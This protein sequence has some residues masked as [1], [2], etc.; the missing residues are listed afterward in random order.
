MAFFLLI[1]PQ[2]PRV[3]GNCRPTHST[4]PHLARTLTECEAFFQDASCEQTVHSPQFHHCLKGSE[5]SMCA[6]LAG[7]FLFFCILLFVLKGSGPDTVVQ[8]SRGFVKCHLSFL[9]KMQRIYA[10]LR[11]ALSS[12][13]IVWWKWALLWASLKSPYTRH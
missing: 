12:S 10:W 13:W 1:S 3:L 11:L 7:H 4:L 9:V 6:F 2:R 8:N 5:P